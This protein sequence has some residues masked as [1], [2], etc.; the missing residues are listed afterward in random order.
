MR[1]I[2]LGRE[3]DLKFVTESGNPY[4]DDESRIQIYQDEKQGIE[5]W[6]NAPLSF[7]DGSD[8]SA[9]LV[10][11]GPT[12]GTPTAGHKTGKPGMAKELRSQ[13]VAIIE[14]VGIDQARRSSL[15]PLEDNRKGIMYFFRW[16]DFTKPIRE[17]ELTPFIQVALYADGS[18]AGY[19][20]TL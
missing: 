10:Q 4:K 14:K 3:L 16:D 1:A 9:K 5:V 19:T 12:A 8:E 20:N 2:L 7:N 11:I 18:L 15:H 17:S 6:T 13:A